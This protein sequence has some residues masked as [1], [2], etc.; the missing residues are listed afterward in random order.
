MVHTLNPGTI[1]QKLAYRVMGFML[2]CSYI[3]CSYSFSFLLTGLGGG[4]RN[5]H[6]HKTLMDWPLKLIMISVSVL[7]QSKM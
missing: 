6:G 5:M 2:A 1:F 4:F 7:L 3:L